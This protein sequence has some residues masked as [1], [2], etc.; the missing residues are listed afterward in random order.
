MWNAGHQIISSHQFKYWDLFNIFNLKYI[1]SVQINQQNKNILGLLFMTSGDHGLVPL[2][3]HVPYLFL[4]LHAHLHDP[5]HL[6]KKIRQ[7]W[8]ISCNIFWIPA[9]Y[10]QDFYSSMDYPVMKI[11]LFFF[12]KMNEW[13][14][15]IKFFLKKYLILFP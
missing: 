13:K 1:C 11:L 3:L 6:L 10:D 12:Q 15:F 4:Y 7:S 8:Y 2:G 9:F 5:Y 14:N